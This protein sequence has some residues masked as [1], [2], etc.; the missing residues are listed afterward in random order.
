[1]STIGGDPYIV[2]V[3]ALM[4]QAFGISGLRQASRG[5]I[6]LPGQPVSPQLD[7]SG[8]GTLPDRKARTIGPLGTPI[9]DELTVKAGTIRHSG[10]AFRGFRFPPA[11]VI[12]V[13]GPAKIINR[14]QVSGGL[15]SVVEFGGK[16]DYSLTIRG[17]LVNL[18]N[19]REPPHEQ[20]KE[21][22]RVLNI[23]QELEVTCELLQQFNINCLVLGDA[24]FPEVEGQD[25]VQP[26]SIQ[27]WSHVPL[28]IEERKQRRIRPDENGN[29]YY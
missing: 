12:S 4:L 24:E 8:I 11:T 3:A 13:S 16:D 26:F 15:G 27:A 1:M 14:T 10:E 6:S 17:L 29:F 2:P 9:F 19:P 20:M 28:L 21:L 25:N 7:F 18:D 5:D 23:E 22:V